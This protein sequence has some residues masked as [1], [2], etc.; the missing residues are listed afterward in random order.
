M[1]VK[2]GGAAQT[3]GIAVD[4]HILTFAQQP[5]RSY[6]AML[7]LVQHVQPGDDV[8]L[9]TETHPITLTVCSVPASG[10]FIVR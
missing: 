1:E 9:V 4:E 8:Q 5:V 3:A 6:A 7:T 2:A 10:A